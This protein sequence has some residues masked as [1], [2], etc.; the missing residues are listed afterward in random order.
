MRVLLVGML[1]LA[2]VGCAGPSFTTRPIQNDPLVFIGLA[3]YQ[4]RAE[5]AAVRHD[6]PAA[7][8]D[9]D[10]RAILGR[11]LLQE[12]GGLMDPTRPPKPVFA[13]EEIARLLP[14]LR[15][16]FETARPSDWVVFVLSDAAG[17]STTPVV[18]SGALA[19]ENRRLHVILA[20]HHEPVS[21]GTEA[22]EKLRVHPF[23]PMRG[24]RGGLAFDPPLYVVNSRANWLGGSSGAAAGEL[25]L[26]HL[27]FLGTTHRAAPSPQGSPVADSEVGKLREE[28]SKLR[29]ELARVKEQL[30]E[31][32]EELAK[33]RAQPRAR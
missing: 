13:T 16:A 11:L 18:T 1:L 3:S 9:A 27:S 14:G 28:V 25:V 22:Q 30:K 15:Q 24:L 10:L 17:T 33:L 20:N 32:T 12:R 7:W 21:P 6:H 5:A 4:D 29:E 26:D 23:R 19:L 8:A 2:G 31:Q